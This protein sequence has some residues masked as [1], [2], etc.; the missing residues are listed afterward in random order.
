MEENEK[1]IAENEKINP[2]DII[3][4]DEVDDMP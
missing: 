1:Q 3:F 4:D 2:A